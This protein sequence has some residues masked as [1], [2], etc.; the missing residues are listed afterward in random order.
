MDT[1]VSFE[2]SVSK[3]LHNTNNCVLR[4]AEKIDEENTVQLAKN[5]FVFSRFHLD[6]EFT[7]KESATIKG[8]WVRNF[9]KGQRGD[10][11]ILALVN[12]QIVGFLQLLKSPQDT[13]VIDLIAVDEKQRKKGIAGDMISFA[14]KNIKGIQNIKVGTQI[15][16]IPSIRFYQNIGFKFIG[17][18]YVFHYHHK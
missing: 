12:N 7:S 14:E 8:E 3:D 18:N 10:F 5:S 16:N 1:N 6:K 2:K 4:F 9:F 17:A 13:L 15:A 11:M